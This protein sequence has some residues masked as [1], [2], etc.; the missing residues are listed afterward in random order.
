MKITLHKL[1]RC[2][3]VLL[4]IFWSTFA[5]AQMTASIGNQTKGK[6]SEAKTSKASRKAQKSLKDFLATLEKTF[7]VYFTFESSVIRDKQIPGEVN[8]SNNL[9]ETLQKVLSPHKL[10]FEKVSDNYYS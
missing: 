7:K 3:T 4:I 5:S 9:E 8:I 6:K 10:K 2:S 1:T